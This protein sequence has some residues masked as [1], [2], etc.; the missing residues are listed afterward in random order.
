MLV[1]EIFDL[2]CR[3]SVSVARQAALPWQTI[4]AP[5]VG[6]LPHIGFQ[7]RTWCDHTVL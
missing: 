4:C 2:N 1:F 3:L 6:G 5:L 7:V